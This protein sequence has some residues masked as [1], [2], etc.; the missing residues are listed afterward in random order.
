MKSVLAKGLPVL[1]CLVSHCS[2]IN[3]GASNH[4]WQ[5]K[6]KIPGNFSRMRAFVFEHFLGWQQPQHKVFYVLRFT[7]LGGTFA[8]WWKM[9]C[10][11]PN[12]CL[13]LSSVW[14]QLAKSMLM[15]FYFLW[16]R[17]AAAVFWQ[18]Y[19]TI[20]LLQWSNKMTFTPCFF[21]K[22]Q[23]KYKQGAIAWW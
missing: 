1:K 6:Q 16:R 2:H 13:P 3:L 11:S 15:C 12:W 21:Q 19:H 4:L 22:F 5:P 20:A 14:L 7:F 8:A 9:S 17:C 23:I 10:L 18:Q